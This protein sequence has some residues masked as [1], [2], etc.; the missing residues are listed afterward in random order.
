MSSSKAL[1]PSSPKSPLPPPTPGQHQLSPGRRHGLPG[2]PFHRVCPSA[3]PSLQSLSGLVQEGGSG[4][5]VKAALLH[6][7]SIRQRKAH[8]A[9]S[10]PACLKDTVPSTTKCFKPQKSELSADPRS[11][12]LLPT[13]AC[14]PAA[15]P[16]GPHRQVHSRRVSRSSLILG[17]KLG[18]AWECKG[19]STEQAHWVPRGTSECD[20]IWKQ[21]LCRGN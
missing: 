6:H 12:R 5:C 17:E 14:R 20:L 9:V 7:R 11:P 3:A 10:T 19:H 1:L 8:L 15:G 13:A 18:A 4:L 16:P 2:A 21:G